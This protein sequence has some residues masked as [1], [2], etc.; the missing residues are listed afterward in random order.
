MAARLPP[1][2]GGVLMG[3]QQL[4]GRQAGAEKKMREDADSP[5][6]VPPETA[7]FSSKEQGICVEMK[8]SDRR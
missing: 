6:T 7:I 1:G 4:P 5:L 2:M 3:M 8:F